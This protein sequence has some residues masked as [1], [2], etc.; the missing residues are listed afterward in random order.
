MTVSLL[1]LAQLSDQIYDSLNGFD[2]SFSLNDVVVGHKIIDGADVFVIRGSLTADD[3]MHDAEAIPVWHSSLG[4]C[5]SG[6]I[7]GM[8]DCYTWA[9]S[10]ITDLSAGIFIT[11]HSLGGARARLLAAM[12]VCDKIP[13]DTLCVFG[14]PKPAFI[15][16]A[17]IIQK[18]GMNHY[19]FRNRNDIVPT[20]P[21][22]L[23]MWEHTEQ[24]EVVN[25]CPASDD[26]SP[27]RDHSCK[28]YVQALSPT[29]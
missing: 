3:W 29:S 13:V 7:S 8:D 15:N 23:P 12:F 1:M 21:C 19:S 2:H 24:Y 9:K 6:F 14:S 11:G 5:H 28:L 20:M 26:F 10:V 17:R 22:I 25:C 4:F 27:L 18:S 16:V